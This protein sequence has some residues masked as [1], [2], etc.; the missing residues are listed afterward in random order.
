MISVSMRNG[1]LAVLLAGAWMAATV[2]RNYGGHISALF[3]LGDRYRMP[4]AVVAE[5]PYVFPNSVGYDGQSYLLLARDPWLTREEHQYLDAPVQRAR[6]IL[7]PALAWLAALGAPSRVWMTYPLIVL[8]LIGLGASSRG[9][10]FLLLPATLISMDRMVV[11]GALCAFA[12]WWFSERGSR[13]GYVALAMAA[14]T[15]ETGFLL[16]AGACAAELTER[17]WR[18]ALTYACCALPAL[19]WYAWL[20]TKMTA[21]ATELSIRPLVSIVHGL[22]NPEYDASRLPFGALLRAMD[23]VALAA[24]AAM[25]VL[26]VVWLARGPR[27]APA[28]AAGLFGLAGLLL[29]LDSSWTHVYS[30]GRIF[31]PLFLLLA[32]ASPYRKSA[33]ALT[34][35][36]ALRVLAQL[37]PQAA[38]IVGLHVL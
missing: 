33:L 26:A 16:I 34:G 10:L 3:Q 27:T 36:V 21:G 30:F 6:R 31:S 12:A 28:W 2:E 32:T 17:R 9:L 20:K 13:W 35:L 38:G 15:R 11:D 8:L 29:S 1:L 7:L 4:A 22:R 5:H 25:L 19:G 24:T 14:L 23:Y 37:A 18:A